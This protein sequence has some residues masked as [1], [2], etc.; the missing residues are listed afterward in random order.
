M[1][2]FSIGN[3]NFEVDVA[4]SS[5]S[6]E[7]HG[8]GMLEL[9]ID[10]HGDDEVFMRLT[11]PEDAEWSWALY[12]PAF[13]LHGLR[14]PKGQGGALAIGML[15]MHPEAEESGIYMMEYGDVSAVNIIELSADRLAM[16]GMVDLCGKHLPFHIDMPRG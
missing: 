8:S 1:T 10:I 14:I 6:L 13:F 2:V 5:I 11:E 9:N 3:T 12:P 4:K 16:S 15:D 7:A